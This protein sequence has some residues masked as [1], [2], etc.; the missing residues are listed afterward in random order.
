MNVVLAVIGLIALLLFSSTVFRDIG[1]GM[2]LNPDALMIVLGGTVVAVFLGFPFRRLRTAVADIAD[3]FRAKSDRQR[4]S[5]DLLD[6]ARIY[7][8]ADIQGLERKMTAISNEFLK[9]GVNLLINHQPNDE[10]RANMERA[11]ALRVMNYHHSQNV[12]KAIARLTPSFGLAGTVVS[13]I[14]MFQHMESIDAIAPHMGVA[15]MSTFYG[16]IIANLFMIPL[17]AK[18]E[19]H[20]I[21]S[22]ALMLSTIEGIEAINNRDHPLRVEERVN[23]FRVT[24]GL[25]PVGLSATSA[26]TR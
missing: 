6:V 24:G 3:T 22:E 8:R 10:I 14:K 15:M 9:L 5:Q 21:Q 23:G 2:L 4:T 1:L 26:M 11:M 7:R 12:L 19:E 17:C 20:A 16:V 25:S 13:L 18:L